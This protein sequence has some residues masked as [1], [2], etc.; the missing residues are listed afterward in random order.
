MNDNHPNQGIRCLRELITAQGLEPV[1]FEARYKNEYPSLDEFD[2]FIFSG[3]P[4]DPTTCLD[5]PWGKN[6]SLLIDAIRDYNINSATGKK[7]AFMICHSFQML[8]LHWQVA[9]VNKRKSTSFGILPCHK[10]VL[11]LGDDVLLDGLPDPFYVVDSRDFQIVQ[12]DMDVLASQGFEVVCLEKIREHVPY[13]R[14]VMAIRFSPEI[15]GTQF[16]PEAD[17]ESMRFYLYNPEKEAY[18]R[19]RYGDAKYAEMVHLMDATDAV[20]ATNAQII[21]SFLHFAVHGSAG[22]N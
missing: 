9:E 22:N 17:V 20:Q 15:F 7:Y 11:P 4:G 12:P 21:P 13:E 5:T 16:H 3:G 2:I 10:A 1:V 19:E 6:F 8:V 18:V 14:A